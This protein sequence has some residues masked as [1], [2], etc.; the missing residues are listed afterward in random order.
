MFFRSG[1]ECG[2]HR[3]L[4]VENSSLGILYTQLYGSP[5]DIGQTTLLCW[6]FVTITPPRQKEQSF[7]PQVAWLPV[8]ALLSGWVLVRD[9]KFSDSMDFELVIYCTG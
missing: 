5:E 8:V 7:S 1:K 6:T 9:F 4:I 3:A 2:N